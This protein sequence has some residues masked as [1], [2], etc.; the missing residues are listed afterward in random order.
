METFKSAA[1]NKR[2]AAFLIDAVIILVVAAVLT[3]VVET[4]LNRS[5]SCFGW[6]FASL[7]LIRDSIGGQ[8]PG[9]RWVGLQVV[10]DNGQASG[11]LGSIFRNAFIVGGVLAINMINDRWTM[12]G[13]GIILGLEYHFMV[14]KDLDGQRLGDSCAGTRVRDLRSQV[15]DH[16]FG[17]LAAGIVLLA[18]ALIIASL[19]HARYGR[20]HAG[21]LKSF[22][23]MP[24]QEK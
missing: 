19:V 12:P 23:D 11:F 1:P 5:T 9:K 8:S 2:K 17:W 3:G 13:T 14:R 16:V 24:A 20:V 7:F 21:R 18:L 10:G 6:I 22:V 15:S 4:I